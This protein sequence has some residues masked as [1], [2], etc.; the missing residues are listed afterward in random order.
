[1]VVAFIVQLAIAHQRVNVAP[2]PS[3]GTMAVVATVANHV[4]M[5]TVA[6]V[7][8]AHA[9]QVV[10]VRWCLHHNLTE[11]HHHRCQHLEVVGMVAQLAVAHLRASAAHQRYFQMMGIA[12]Q[13]VNGAQ[14]VTAARVQQMVAHPPA[15]AHRG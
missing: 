12:A 11:H 14:M 1:V 13:A 7:L 5:V 3:V 15:T 9:W 10:I 6:R 2:Y 8:L 4:A